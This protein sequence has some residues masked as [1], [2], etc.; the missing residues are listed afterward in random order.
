MY[1]QSLSSSSPHNKGQFPVFPPPKK[2]I[3]RKNLVSSSFRAR[4]LIEDLWF[5]EPTVMVKCS[6]KFLHFFRLLSPLWPSP[7]PK[8]GLF[9]S[10]MTLLHPQLTDTTS[11]LPP[12]SHWTHSYNRSIL[13]PCTKFMPCIAQLARQGE[14]P[15]WPAQTVAH[16][17]GGYCCCIS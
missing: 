7:Y 6:F 3:L 17:Q 14:P 16:L 12:T 15:I 1:Y 10:T 13:L 11:P 2:C 4:R 9:S 8:K 5:K